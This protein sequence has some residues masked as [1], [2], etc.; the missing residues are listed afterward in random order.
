MTLVAN[1]RPADPARM[2][3]ARARMQATL[4]QLPDHHD[5]ADMTSFEAAFTAAIG[6]L[7]TEFRALARD[8]RITQNDAFCTIAAFGHVAT[9]RL[10]FIGAL[11]KWLRMI[12][13]AEAGT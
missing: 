8:A 5:F 7:Q 4:D 6:E 13:R 10:G 12:G 9:S 2:R 11:E 1:H 3:D